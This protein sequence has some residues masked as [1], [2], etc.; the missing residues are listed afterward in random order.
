LPGA[1]LPQGEAPR[2]HADPP[3]APT[4]PTRQRGTS[5]R[6]PRQGRLRRHASSR[7]P[8]PASF[9][10]FSQNCRK[11]TSVDT[12]TAPVPAPAMAP[13]CYVSKHFPQTALRERNR[14]RGITTYGATLPSAHVMVE[15]GNEARRAPSREDVRNP[16]YRPCGRLR[17]TSKGPDGFTTRPGKSGAPRPFFRAAR[18]TRQTTNATSERS[19]RRPKRSNDE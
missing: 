19:G 6:S 5:H 14:R 16:R 9:G 4:S 8:L 15:G 11:D 1:M 7:R 2:E 17:P 13:C 3:S 12:Q 18:S 10:N